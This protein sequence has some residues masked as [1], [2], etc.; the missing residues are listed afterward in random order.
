MRDRRRGSCDDAGDGSSVRPASGVWHRAGA[1]IV[2]GARPVGGGAARLRW[3]AASSVVALGVAVGALWLVASVAA[4][5]VAP[6]EPPSPTSL[7]LGWTFPPLP[8]L[9]ILVA[10]VW[11]IW[12]VR[13][14]DAAH[15]ANPVPRRRTVTFLL[16]MLALGFAVASGIERYDTSLFS[17]HMVQHVLLMLVAAPLIA[18]SAPITLVLRLSAPATRKRWILPD[19]PLADRP[20]PRPPRR[21]LDHLRGDDVGDPFLG[22][23]QRLARGPAPP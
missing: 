4:H 5:G 17:V 1:R 7:L 3:R 20:H 8:T 13:R 9:G 14:V 21:G 22:A 2:T 19:P 6:T 16:G 18:L 23:V 12:A 10:T 15:P 11:W